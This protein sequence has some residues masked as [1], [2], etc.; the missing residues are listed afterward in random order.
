MATL[1]TCLDAWTAERSTRAYRQ[2]AQGALPVRWLELPAGRVRVWDSGGDKPCVL[3]APDGPNVLE[4]YQTLVALLAPHLRVVV[5]DMPGF[6]FSVPS[7]DYNHSLDHGAQV[8]LDVM[9]RLGVGRA[10]LAMSCA[11]GF[12]AMRAAQKAPER[13]NGL[14]L[15]QT[16]SLAAMHRW[17]ERVVPWP[18]TVPVLGQ[19]LGLA[20]KQKMASGWYRAA[21]PKWADA[22]AFQ[23][24]SRE[25][26]RCGACFGLAGV[27][28]GLMRESAQAVKGVGVACTVLW[29]SLDRSHK[30]THS[31][32]VQQDMPQAQVQL[33]DDCGHFPDLEQ[34]Q[35]FASLLLA[36]VKP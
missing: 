18:I 14:F 30:H 31:H 4:H 35:R 36:H 12:Y 1:S 33:F 34:P 26:M 5:F 29:G 11:N 22:G 13:V 2:N 9:D 6:G 8:M 25:A 27:V 17:T 16:P 20:F 7:A 15:S 19:L 23:Q 32:A 10:T 28:Q 24:T 3:L 21:L